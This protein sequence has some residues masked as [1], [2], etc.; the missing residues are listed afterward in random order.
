[1]GR[2]VIGRTLTGSRA[3]GGVVDI[4]GSRGGG[5]EGVVEVE[6]VECACPAEQIRER[7]MLSVLYRGRTLGINRISGVYSICSESCV[8]GMPSIPSAS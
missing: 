1:M 3:G 6:T 7:N 4:V 5:G 8:V 2:P